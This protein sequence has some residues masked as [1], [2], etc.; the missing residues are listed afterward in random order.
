MK[1]K[2]GIPRTLWISVQ[3]L[4]LYYYFKFKTWIVNITKNYLINIIIKELRLLV[5]LDLKYITM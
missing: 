1:R 3:V 2:I 5:R 4:E